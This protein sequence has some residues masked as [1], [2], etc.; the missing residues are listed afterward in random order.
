ML[1]RFSRVWLC[2]TLWTALGQAPL[3][4]EY[5]RQEY[6]N[7]LP[8]PTPGD[9]PNLEIEPASLKFPTLAGGFF[10]NSTTWEDLIL[11]AQ[12]SPSQASAICEP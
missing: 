5:S 1:S 4:M 7:G 9:L 3:S 12:N 11:Y 10:T 6:W 2:V 8:F